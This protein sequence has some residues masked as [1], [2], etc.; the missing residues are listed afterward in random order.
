[1]N[2][3]TKHPDAV[4]DLRG[5]WRAWAGPDEISSSTWTIPDGIQKEHDELLDNVVCIRL[6]GG[7]PGATYDFTNHVATSDGRT[8]GRTYRVY[9]HPR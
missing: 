3:Y 5:D 7:A 8:E 1:M 6:S 9:V 2:M 4:L